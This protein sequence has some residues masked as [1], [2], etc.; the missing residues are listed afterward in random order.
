MPPLP[1]TI[2]AT[3]ANNAR[4]VQT[5]TEITQVIDITLTDGRKAQAVISFKVASANPPDGFPWDATI[6]VTGAL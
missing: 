6:T 1:T 4:N 5:A 2:K 3:L